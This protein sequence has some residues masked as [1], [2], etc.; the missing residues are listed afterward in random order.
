MITEITRE[1]LGSIKND[2]F[3]QD[4]EVYVRSYEKFMDAVK[5]SGIDTVGTISSCGFIYKDRLQGE[6]GIN[7]GNSGRSLYTG[8]L[9]PACVH[10]RTGAGSMTVFQT[11]KCNR[12]C[13]FCAN[14]NQE[15]YN[16]YVENI[17][18]A[19]AELASA[20][21]G[22]G[23][24]SI[25]LTGGEPL[26][27]SEKAVSFFKESRAKYKDAHLRLYTNGDFLT[28][29]LAKEL[30]DAG[31]DEIRISVKADNDGYPDE[32]L[33]SISIS[34]KHIPSVMVEMPVIPGTLD[35]MKELLVKLDAIGCKGINI[36]EFLYPWVN[37]ERYA[38][39]GLKV[40]GRPYRVFYSYKYAGGLPVDGSAE[41]CIELLKFAAEKGLKM[42][43]HFCS[44]EN[45][46]TSQI[47]GQNAGIRLMPYEV[48][49]P[50]DFFIKTARVYGSSSLKAEKYFRSKG[51]TDYVKDRSGLVMD[52]HPKH[53][54][55]M[56]GIKEAAIT[57]SVAE[58]DGRNTVIKEIRMDLADPESFI[59]EEDI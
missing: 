30:A 31:L 54:G 34:V 12:D 57:Y 25:A 47:Y 48:M 18:D 13:Y 11:L 22:E 43:V 51:I 36:L 37:N 1:S 17:N 35:V 33:K 40:K 24:R 45:K 5:D 28:E 26:L 8:E 21:R 4:A 53:L 55:S 41:D 44:L 19:V 16:Y 58:N 29:E 38:E 50:K 2:K 9:S 15:N 23:F 3:R 52:F 14:M 27:L 46:L 42:G 32:T 20:D 10:C 7:V 56:S 6:S 59:Y 39:R 49:S